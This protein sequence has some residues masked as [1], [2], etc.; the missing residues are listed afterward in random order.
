MVYPVYNQGPKVEYH[1]IVNQTLTKE[2]FEEPWRHI[3]ITYC[4]LAGTEE[5]MHPK[6]YKYIGYLLV[7][8]LL[9]SIKC[10]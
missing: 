2:K 6:C 10:A 7:Y 5:N 4:G 9:R 8:Y 3:L 1:K